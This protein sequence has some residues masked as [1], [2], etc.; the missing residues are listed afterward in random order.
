MIK[1]RTDIWKATNAEIYY[2]VEALKLVDIDYSANT[3]TIIPI[4][5][6][7]PLSMEFK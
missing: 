1:E 7:T 5:M 4:W 6:Y 2:Y 3:I